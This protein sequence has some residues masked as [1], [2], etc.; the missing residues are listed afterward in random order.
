MLIFACDENDQSP[1][2]SWHSTTKLPPLALLQRMPRP[3]APLVAVPTLHRNS[4]GLVHSRRLDRHFHV[5][6]DWATHQVDWRATFL[7]FGYDAGS[8]FSAV[9]ARR[10]GRW[11]REEEL[12]A[13]HL[14]QLFET[15]SSRQLRRVTLAASLHSDEMRVLKKL[16]NSRHRLVPMADIS[17]SELRAAFL[18]STQ[19]E[20]LLSIRIHLTDLVLLP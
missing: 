12:Y 14:L 5:L 13:A 16:N 6:V 9:C 19:L 4:F 20:A 11:R 15:T 7:R 8:V 10:K 18:K 3:A 1:P 17:C 2:F